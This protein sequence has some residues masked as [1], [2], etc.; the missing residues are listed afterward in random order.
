[1]ASVTVT[2]TVLVLGV[3]GLPEISP[4]VALMLKPVGNPVCVHVY[5][6]V[7]PDA[8]IVLLYAAPTCPVGSGEAVVIASGAVIVSVNDFCVVWWLGAVESVTV[9]FTEP[10]L[11]AVGEPEITPPELIVK[12]VGKPVALQV[13]GAVPPV[14]TN[15]AE[16]GLPAGLLGKDA[17]VIESAGVMFSGSCT[18]LLWGVVGVESVTVMLTFAE[19]APPGVPAITPPEF[20]FKPVGKPVAA[21]VYGGVPPVAD[22][23]NE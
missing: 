4:V 9:T 1:V 10:E 12:P 13:Y 3:E 16:Y 2:F 22:S 8:M 11:A 19:L 18:V 17:V 20:I 15:V 7:P 14:A 5:G 23:V 21:Q 6:A